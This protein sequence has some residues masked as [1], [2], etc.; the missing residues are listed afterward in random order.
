MHR[1]AAVAVFDLFGRLLLQERDEDAPHDPERWG[2]PGGDLEPGEDFVTAA[3]RELEEE[4]GLVVDPARLQSLGSHRFRSASCGGDDVFELFAVRLSVSQDDLVCGEGRQVLLVDPADLGDRE[5]HQ[6]TA[7]TLDR[8]REWHA[9]SVRTD[10]VQVTLVDPRG[11]V[12]M[13]E[14]DEHAPV[15]PDMWCFPGGG[16]EEGEEPAA[17]AA[18]EL[19][20][21]TGVVLA[22]EELTDLG[23][24]ELA[25]DRGTF[26]FHAFVARTTLTDR[27]VE[28]HEGR[29]M[30]FVDPDPL[31][32]LDL[33]PSTALVAP[34]LLEWIAQ[35]PR[36]GDDHRRRFAGVILVDA[37]GW[38]LLQERDEHPRIDP[39]KWGLAGGHL[40]PGEDFV[41]GAAR[42]LEEE[43]GVRLEP[44]QLALLGE[45]A[46]DHREAYGT[47]DLMQVFAARTDLTDADIDCREGRQIV[48]VDPEVARG[49]DLSA[50][51]VDIVPAFLASRLYATMAL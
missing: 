51:A 23:L 35:H 17:G 18:R 2:Y 22:P 25:T 14:R 30:V 38:L 10:F 36:G 4:T 46:V 3:V 7:L 43:T 12:L 28:C 13:Q 32:G 9:T 6:A 41:V 45:F 27:D 40:E 16:L 19:A 21:E 26:R 44:D 50:A 24:F 47:W 5:L 29:Q 49:L 8:V 1:F 37:R 42:E 33:V 31:P 39:E 34:A 11:R 15:W 48:F 20:E